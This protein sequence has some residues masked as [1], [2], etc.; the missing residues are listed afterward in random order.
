[1]KK[2]V[3]NNRRRKKR[4]GTKILVLLWALVFLVIGFELFFRNEIK[5]ITL[6]YLS[7]VSTCEISKVKET[8]LSETE[9]VSLD[10]F[11]R[12]ENVTAN[13]ALLLVNEKYKISEDYIPKTVY[14]DERAVEMNA[15]AKDSFDNL[16][17]AL[18]DETGETLFI[19]SAYRDYEKQKEV[20]AEEGETAQEAGC[21]E[22][23]TGLALDVFVK[24]FAGESFIK[25]E[26]G[27]FI[28]ENCGDYGFIIRYPIFGE[29]KTG[30]SFEPWHLRYVGLPHSKIINESKITFEDYIDSFEMGKL[31]S[32]ENYIITRQNTDTISVPEGFE[33]AVASEDNTGAVIITFKME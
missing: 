1:M 6:D 19:S 9:S 15:C 13:E 5:F 29:K 20:K 11:L 31:Y 30:I 27:Q 25:S 8:K 12:Y 10:E 22:H 24:N 14:H 18:F 7:R 2:E 26:S 16:S 17:E 28:N 4:N 33:G 32:Y 23:Q 3:K 21:S